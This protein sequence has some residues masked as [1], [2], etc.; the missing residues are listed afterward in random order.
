MDLDEEVSEAG[1]I[2][3]RVM[4]DEH[5][6]SCDEDLFALKFKVLED[7]WLKVKVE[8]LNDGGLSL[9][10]EFEVGKRE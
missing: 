5:F 8:L 6:V 1:E 9:G 4:L 10:N 2:P 3:I 7:F